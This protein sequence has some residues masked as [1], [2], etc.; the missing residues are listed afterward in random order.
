MTDKSKQCLYCA[1][2]IHVA[3]IR[4]R[5]CGETLPGSP[6]AMLPPEELSIHTRTVESASGSHWAAACLILFVLAIAVGWALGILD[7]GSEAGAESLRG[8][9]A[10][11]GCDWLRSQGEEL[12]R[13]MAASANTPLEYEH[14][15]EVIGGEIQRR[16]EEGVIEPRLQPAARNLVDA[17][18]A[19]VAAIAATRADE[20]EIT[21]ELVEHGDIAAAKGARLIG[22]LCPRSP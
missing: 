17:T 2:T 9:S 7:S 8:E 20:P 10:I 4:C 19:Y 16:I 22:E 5:F 6:P 3:A 21:V 12:A 18:N 1:E 15:F 11:V 13:V 14:D